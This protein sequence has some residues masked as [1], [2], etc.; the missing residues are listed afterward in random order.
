MTRAVL[1][2]LR[3]VAMAAISKQAVSETKP[4]P[5]Q[6]EVHD[7]SVFQTAF[8]PLQRQQL[9]EDDRFASTAIFVI[10][11]AIFVMGLGLSIGA[12]WLAR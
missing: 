4:T 1:T 8:T 11:V 7:E 12:I 2:T 9:L 6:T 3:E 5:P 10:L